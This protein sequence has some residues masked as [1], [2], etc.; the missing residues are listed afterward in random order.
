MDIMEISISYWDN[1][2]NW[3]IMEI[4]ISFLIMDIPW[5]KGYNWDI[6]YDKMGDNH[7]SWKYHW[8]NN[9]NIMG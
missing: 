8:T 2:Y 5:F 3:D 4:S 9:G 1:G 6:M 7:G